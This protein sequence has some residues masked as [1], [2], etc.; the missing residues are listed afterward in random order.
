MKHFPRC[1]RPS[2]KKFKRKMSH[3]LTTF[4]RYA[5]GLSRKASITGL[6]VHTVNSLGNLVLTIRIFTRS[7]FQIPVQIPK[8]Q[9]LV[10]G[11]TSSGARPRA[12]ASGGTCPH[13]DNHAKGEK[14]QILLVCVCEGDHTDQRYRDGSKGSEG[15]EGSEGIGGIASDREGS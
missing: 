1:A 12:R 13:S 2:L 8:F 3:I 15:S 9:R 6:T 11:C 14:G 5:R 10:L 4:P 7:N